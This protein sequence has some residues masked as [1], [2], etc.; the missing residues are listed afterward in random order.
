[1]A[2]CLNGMAAHGGVRPFGSTFLIFTDYCKPSIRLSGLMG[3]PVIFIGTHDSIGLGEDGPTHQPIE[4]L[5]TLRATPNVT[6]IRPAD[7]T[8]TVEAWRTAIERQDGPTVLALTRQ[9][10]PV[11]DRTK[12]GAVEGARRGGYTLLDCPGEP[13]AIVL[14]TGSEVHVALTAVERLQVEGLRVRLVSLPSWELF[15]RQ[16]AAYRE[17]VLPANVKARVSIEAATTFGWQRY[18]GDRGVSIGIDRFG[19]S[20]PGDTLFT[21]FGFTAA[22]VE[23]VVKQ[24]LN[25]QS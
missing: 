3:L 25:R 17:S 10:V 9:K 22:R 5:A 23:N 21:E 18:V 20:A 4:Q 2:A 1:M 13:Q 12:L 6:V 11:L 19:A 7:A 15:D 16:D 8:E 24:L 14:A